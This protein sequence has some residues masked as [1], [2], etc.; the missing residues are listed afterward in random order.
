MTTFYATAKLVKDFRIDVDDGRSHTVC[1]DLPLDEGTDMGPSPLELALMSYAGCYATIFV[2]TA[3]KMR[4]QLRD[5]EVALEAVKSEE[6]RTITQVRLDIMV[7]ADTPQNRIERAHE[8]TLRNCPVG[9]LFE[10]ANVKIS[11][12]LK[13]ETKSG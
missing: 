1:L 12:N 3:R 10:K 13:T 6:V 2:K 8:V 5:L 11:Y 7:K 9:I 4:M